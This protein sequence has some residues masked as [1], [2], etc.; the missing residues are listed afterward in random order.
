VNFNLDVTQQN[1]SAVVSVAG[2]LDIY[3]APRLD[4]AL[5][6]PEVEAAGRVVVDLTG[7]EFMDSTGL[8]VLV[9]AMKRLTKAG[10]EFALVCAPSQ[11][12]LRRVM[13]ITGLLGVFTIHGSREEAGLDR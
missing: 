8:S 5:N 2:E 13:E 4:E 12:D 1:A 7:T 3:T 6:Q 10:R 11:R 9:A